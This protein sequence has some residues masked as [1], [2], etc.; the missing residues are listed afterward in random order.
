MQYMS[1]TKKGFTLL[2]L[3]IIVVLVSIVAKITFSSFASLN[4][5]EVLDSQVALIKSTIQKARLESLNSKNGIAHGVRFASTTLTI[6]DQGVDTM[7]V[8]SFSNG[9]TLASQ[10]LGTTSVTFAKVTGLSSASGT[11]TYTLT[12]GNTVIATTSFSIN[13]IGVIQ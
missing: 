8:V 4:N 7:R 12:R 10:T 2:E 3:V 13:G 5:R 6:T 11:L 1:F 9:V